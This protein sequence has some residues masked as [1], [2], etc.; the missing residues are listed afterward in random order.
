MSAKKIEIDFEAC[1]GCKTCMNA[2]FVDVIRW[3]KEE[4][5]PIVAYPE[6]CVWCY[7]CEIACPEQCIEVV[8]EIKAHIEIA[9]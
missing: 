3:D 5:K 9:I 4:K 7:A 2:C 8:P 6:D 1:S